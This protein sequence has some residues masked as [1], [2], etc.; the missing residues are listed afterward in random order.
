LD[1]QVELYLLAD[2]FE[3]NV[4]FDKFDTFDT[5][6]N[7]LRSSV[8]RRTATGGGVR[9]SLL[10]PRFAQH[11]T[12]S[13]LSTPYRIGFVPPSGDELLAGAFAPRL[14]LL[15]S[16]GIQQVRHFRHHVELA[17]F[18]QPRPT[19]PWGGGRFSLFASPR[20]DEFDEFDTFDTLSN[21]LRCF[22][23]SH[24][25]PAF[26]SRFSIPTAT[27]TRPCT[28]NLTYCILIH[29]SE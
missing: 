7:W 5:V 15:A 6:S 22:R 24:L 4:P 1:L 28:S 13:T 20:F 27:Q 14:P 2:D 12:N 9:A 11:S 10:A 3:G 16:P 17:S 29:V 18:R 21:W 25:H 26:A 19:L 8:R 23:A